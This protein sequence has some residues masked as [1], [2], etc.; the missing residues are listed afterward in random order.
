MASTGKPRFP[1]V[2]QMGVTRGASDLLCGSL[3]TN[4]NNALVARCRRLAPQRR[5]NKQ[6]TP[7]L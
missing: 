1:L 4:V 2:L 5:S 7:K 6:A 3:R